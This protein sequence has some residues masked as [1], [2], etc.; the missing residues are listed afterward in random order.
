MDARYK[1]KPTNSVAN[2]TRSP[3]V[4][5]DVVATNKEVK[6]DNGAVMR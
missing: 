6:D 2:R 4:T 5:N 3:I 1:W